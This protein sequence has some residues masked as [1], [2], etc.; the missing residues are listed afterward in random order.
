MVEVLG[1]GLA[2]TTIGLLGAH[3]IK[4]LSQDDI[5]LPHL[6]CCCSLP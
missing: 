2:A 3:L 4:R 1:T 5:Y 6:G